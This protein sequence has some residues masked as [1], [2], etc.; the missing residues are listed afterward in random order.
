[1]AATT[2]AIELTRRAVALA[3]VRS[4]YDVMIASNTSTRTLTTS[5]SDDLRFG[6]AGLNFASV[7]AVPQR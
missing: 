7:V 6:A 2:T 1:M 5:D 3:A 4:R